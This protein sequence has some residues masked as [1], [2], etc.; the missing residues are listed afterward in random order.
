MTTTG[1]SLNKLFGFNTRPRA[2]GLYSPFDQFQL[3]LTNLDPNIDY[4]FLNNLPITD[5]VHKYIL[6]ETIK[7]VEASVQFSDFKANK[8]MV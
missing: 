6:N 2:F 4:S 8:I 3:K 7:N 1:G 5:K